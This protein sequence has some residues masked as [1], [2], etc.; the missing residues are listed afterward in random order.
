MTTISFQNLKPK[1]EKWFQLPVLDTLSAFTSVSYLGSRK[2]GLAQSSCSDGPIIAQQSNDHDAVAACVSAGQGSTTTSRAVNIMICNCLKVPTTAQC[3]FAR[4]ACQ[5]LPYS[6]KPCPLPQY[7]GTLCQ[8]E[9]R[10]CI[11]LQ[12]CT[13]SAIL[14]NMPVSQSFAT[15]YPKNYCVWSLYHWVWQ[16]LISG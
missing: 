3:P 16:R 14:K 12:H 8:T 13:C 1:M 5:N 2:L 15:H 9:Y 6:N 11:W 10:H 7:Y 4:W